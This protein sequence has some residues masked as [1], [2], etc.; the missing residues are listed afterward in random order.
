M[1]TVLDVH[2]LK[3]SYGTKPALNDV[4][5]SIKGGTCFGLLG[6]NGAGKSTTMK[7]LTG[8]IAADSGNALVFGLD[9][10]KDRQGIQRQVG[11]V[12]QEITLY[13]KLSAY[14]NLVF[15][16]RPVRTEG[17]ASKKK[18]ELKRC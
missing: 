11:Y 9:A 8:I 2:H 1:E 13:D 12:P 3:K 16:R 18:I 10:V 5:F 7:I 17:G 15:F 14:D 6:P 4:S